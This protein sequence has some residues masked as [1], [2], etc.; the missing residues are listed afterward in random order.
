M[1][2]GSRR[3]SRAKT[4]LLVDDSADDVEL[5]I[6]AFQRNGIANEVIVASDGEEALEFLFATASSRTGS[7]PTIRRS[8]CST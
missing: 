4:I 6:R 8:C 3:M 2:Y 1:R 5:T 7:P